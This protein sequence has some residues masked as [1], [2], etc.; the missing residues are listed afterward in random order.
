MEQP[1]ALRLGTKIVDED[2]FLRRIP[3]W[4]VKPTGEISSAAYQNDP[5]ENSFSTNWLKFS[6]VEAT[7]RD[8]QD[9]G[10][11]SIQARLCWDLKQEIEWTPKDDNTAH[12]DVIGHKTESIHKK[13]RN[14]ATILVYPKKPE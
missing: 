14:G 13:F 1:E 10:V 8:H 2:Q 5:G 6:S 7:L 11:A 4:H 3:P 12:S 9:F